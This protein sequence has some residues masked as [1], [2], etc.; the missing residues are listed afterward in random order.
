MKQEFDMIKI[1]DEE[2]M[3]GSKPSQFK[4]K[5]SSTKQSRKKNM[6]KNQA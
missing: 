3:K 5:D 4:N 2:E 6:P 1:D